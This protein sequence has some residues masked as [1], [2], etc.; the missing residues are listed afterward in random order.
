MIICVLG[1]IIIKQSLC[2]NFKKKTYNQTCYMSTCAIS[3]HETRV[4]ICSTDKF[5]Y[6]IQNVTHN[7]IRMH[8]YYSFVVQRPL[9]AHVIKS[10]F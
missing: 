3:S 2:P 7:A 1:K 6:I 8:E 10:G 5:A 4:I 9:K